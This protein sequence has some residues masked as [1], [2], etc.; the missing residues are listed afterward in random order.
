MCVWDYFDLAII[1]LTV[2]IDRGFII[3]FVYSATI[4]SIVNTNKSHRDKMRIRFFAP[5]PQQ[6]V[7]PVE[8]PKHAEEEE[9]IALD[10]KQLSRQSQDNMASDST[11]LEDNSLEIQ[12]E[13]SSDL[14][15]FDDEQC[16][17]LKRLLLSP[18]EPD[19]YFWGK[20]CSNGLRPTQ[21]LSLEVFRQHRFRSEYQHFWS[22]CDEW[23]KQFFLFLERNHPYNIAFRA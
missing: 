3:K 22:A 17:A 15:E 4:P 14:P 20:Q 10:D 11:S 2:E 16:D 12:Q 21:I 5:I 18:L 9:Q 23:K 7:V 1:L 13:E 6:I 8:T 19:C